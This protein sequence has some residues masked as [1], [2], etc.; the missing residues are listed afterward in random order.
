VPAPHEL[1]ISHASSDTQFVNRL[2][3]VLNRHRIRFWY[4]RSHL[5]GAQQWHDE[6]GKALSRCDWFLLIL[7][8]AAVRSVWVKRELRYALETKRYNDRIIPVLLRACEYGELS[9]TL[10]AIQMIDFAE[11]FEQ[12]CRA[13]FRIWKREYRPDAPKAKRKR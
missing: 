6:I 13:L 9:W 12:G 4:S 5:V 2:I 1:F 11:D 8:P 7:S 10:D 3:R